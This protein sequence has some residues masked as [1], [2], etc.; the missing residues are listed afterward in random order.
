[1]SIIFVSKL[2]NFTD[3]NVIFVLGLKS[4]IKVIVKNEQKSNNKIKFIIDPTSML[5]IPN[6][7]PLV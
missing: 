7:H 2:T 5:H 6:E 3:F 4:T 1:M